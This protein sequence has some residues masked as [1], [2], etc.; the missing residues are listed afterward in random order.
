MITLNRPDVLNAFNG[1]LIA[2]TEQAVREADEDEAVRCLVITGAGRAF[3]SGQDLTELANRHESGEPIDLGQRLCKEYH[4][5][6]ARIRTMEKPVLAS[7]N[8]AAIGA[9]CSLALAC[10]LRIAAESASFVEGFINVGLVP[11]SGSTFMLPR[12]V[13]VSRALELAFTGRKVPPSEALQMGL[14]NRVVPDAELRAESMKL[15]QKLAGQP[16]RAIGLTKR[17]IN[18][19][20]TSDLTT[21]LDLEAELQAIASHTPDHRER[22]LAFIKKRDPRFDGR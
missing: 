15:A 9:G 19:A 14:V 12:L 20:W 10:D 7:V 3:C 6:I 1:D 17:A 22:V 2:A 8:G 18:A 21:Q 5:I 13:G 4:P 11:G 16:T